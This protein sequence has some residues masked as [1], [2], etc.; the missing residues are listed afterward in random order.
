M[1]EYLI[2]MSRWLRVWYCTVEFRTPDKLQGSILLSLLEV[3]LVNPRRKDGLHAHLCHK[4][5]ID[6]RVAKWIEL[7]S[8]PWLDTEFSLQEI[9]SILKVSD[10]VRVIRCSLICRDKSSV[11]DFQTAIIDQ[12]LDLLSLCVRFQVHVVP[13]E[14]CNITESISVLLLY[15]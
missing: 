12:L 14:E 11:Y 13:S 8:D 5:S 2:S 15:L 4:R 6:C 1:H 10:Y 9:M 7:P 3:L